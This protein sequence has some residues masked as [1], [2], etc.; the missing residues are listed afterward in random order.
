LD[1]QRNHE[2]TPYPSQDG[3]WAA[4]PAWSCFPALRGLGVGRFMEREDFNCSF[5]K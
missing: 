4:E 1:A 2:P 5:S 3:N